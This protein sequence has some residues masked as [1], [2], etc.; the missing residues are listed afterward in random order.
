MKEILGDHDGIIRSRP[1]IDEHDVWVLLCFQLF[2]PNDG[3]YSELESDLAGHIKTQ[4]GETHELR[5]AE[6]GG[7]DLGWFKRVPDCRIWLVKIDE[8]ETE[9]L[10]A[11]TIATG[12]SAGQYP[13]LNGTLRP[14][15]NDRFPNCLV[16]LQE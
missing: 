5:Y 8:T 9:Y 7:Q 15:L 6:S 4:S 13:E 3:E 12:L 1:S 10:V 16:S 11:M 2:E 14:R